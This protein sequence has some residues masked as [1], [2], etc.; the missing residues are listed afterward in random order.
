MSMNDGINHAGLGKNRVMQ[1]GIN[2]KSKKAMV[3]YPKM[4]AL[5]RRLIYKASISG[6]RFS[7]IWVR[8]SMQSLRRKGYVAE[9]WLPG[10][11]VQPRREHAPQIQ[12]CPGT[13]RLKMYKYSGHRNVIKGFEKLNGMIVPKE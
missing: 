9:Q 5:K 10:A 1:G 2:S 4:L 12:Q 7:P 11:E 8:D 13:V 6:V 3:C